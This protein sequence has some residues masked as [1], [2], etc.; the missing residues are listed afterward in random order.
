MAFQFPLATV[1]RFRGIIEEREERVLQG[2]LYEIAEISQALRR[3]DVDINSS[4]ASRVSDRFKPSSGSQIH[5]SYA[6]IWELK[7]H[8]VELSADRAKLETL[9]DKQIGIYEAARRDREMLTDMK[10]DKRG[11]YQLEFARQEQKTLDDNYLARRG[12]H[13]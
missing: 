8:K 2:I 9:R 10:K 11:A 5:N 7:Q 1:L 3:I 13:W 4:N 6:A 12:R